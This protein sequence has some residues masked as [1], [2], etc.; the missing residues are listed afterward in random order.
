MTRPSRSLCAAV[1]LL[2][3]AACLAAEPTSELP[4]SGVAVPELAEF[5]RVVPELMRKWGIPGGALGVAKDGRLV[6]ARGYGLAEVE[7]G[8][9]VAPEALF[10]IASLSKPITA[11]AV[12]RMVE[13]GRLGLEEPAW[14]WLTAYHPP[15]GQTYDP[16]LE[17]ITIRQLLQHTA[18]FDRDKSFDPMTGG[19]PLVEAIGPTADQKAII[20]FMFRRPL[21]FDPGQRYVYSNFG[22]CLL[23]RVLE[24]LTGQP[25]DKA[26]EELVLRPAGITRMRLA[27]T[28]QRDR[29][30]GEVCY[31]AFPGAK[32]VRS[33]FADD[34]R[35]VA[36]PYGECYLE[37]MDSHGGWLASSVDLLRFTTALDGPRGPAL[38]APETFRL[39]D[40]EPVER[41]KRQFYGLGWAIAP[42]RAGPCWSHSGS[43]PGTATILVRLPD[44]VAAALLFNSRPKNTGEFF[45]ELERT[46]TKTLR[47]VK[48]WPRGD[49]FGEYP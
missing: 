31:Y 28:R 48:T 32:P 12:L 45:P 20:D 39:I 17:T 27:K 6:L 7:S 24:E 11:A 9:P 43:L 5:D 19:R 37:P 42:S 30:P 2:L 29:A 15:A 44:G 23:G 21:D 36:A 3:G 16:R 47:A 8:E 35:R 46:L 25:Y 38:L 1:V 22:Y 14:K 4:A 18:G 10:R 49:R 26:V 13:R 33:V 41:A 40:A 34:Q